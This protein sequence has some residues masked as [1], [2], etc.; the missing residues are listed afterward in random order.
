MKMSN[1]KAI[2]GVCF[3]ILSVIA[4]NSY[5]QTKYQWKQTTEGG[6]T[7]RYVTGD[8]MHAR[9][10]R[11]KNGLTV[12]LSVNKKEPR[13]Q[14]LIGVRAGSNNDPNDHTGLAHYLEHLLFKGT[15][16][17]GTSDWAKEK[18]YIDEI[19]KL[20]NT[21]NHTKDVA[22]RKAVYHQI[23]SVSGI[24]AHYAI[25]NEYDKLMAEMGAQATNAHT[26]VEETIYQED[27]PSSS[28]DKY[29]AVQAER[30]RY[31]V[32]RL[33]HTELEAVY[34]EKNR[35][36]DNDGQKVFQVMMNGIFPTHNYGQHTTIGTIEHLKN[37]SLTA[38]RNFYN[39]WYVPNNMAIVL[40]GDIDPATVIKKINADFAYMQPKPLHEYS[41]APEA[42]MKAPVI[43]EVLGPDAESV[44][45]AYRM[46]GALDSKAQVLLEVLSDMLSNGKAGLLDLNLN[47]Q[48]KVLS[49]GAFVQPFKDYSMLVISG[50]S[51]KGQS[52]DELKNL[53]QEQIEK[54]KKGDFDPSLVKAIINN[55]RLDQIRG[56]E[57]NT[58]RAN[59]LMDAFIKHKGNNW[60]DDVDFLD[61]MAKVTKA[62]LVNFANQYLGN[63][64]ALVY[65]RLGEDKSI[66]KVEKPAITPIFIDKTSKSPFLERIAAMPATTVNPLW[67]DYQKDIQ[68][69]MVG[70]APM[71]YVPNKD[72]ALFSLSYRFDMGSWNNKMLPYAADYL[73]Y[74]GTDKASAEQL[75]RA[76]YNIA[77]DYH[78]SV[79]GDV[80]TVNITGLQDNFNQAVTLF[81]KL[82]ANCEPNQNAFAALKEG[83]EKSRENNKLNKNAIA[84]GLIQYAMYGP[85]NPF[86]NQ[87]SNQELNAMTADTLVSLLHSLYANKHTVIYYGPLLKAQAQT[88][89][90]R[91]HK[92]PLNFIESDLAEKFEKASQNNNQVLFADYKQVQ[93]EVYWIRNTGV[94]QP[95][96]T[97]DI[98]VYNKYFGGG[99]GSVVFQTIRESKALAYSTFAQYASPDKKEERYS[100]IGYVG[101]QADKM[102]EA[103]NGMNDLYNDMPENE[104][105]LQNAKQ[106][107]KQD[108]AT[109]RITNEDIIKNYLAAQR[110]GLNDDYRK[111]VYQTIDHITFEDI[112]KIHNENLKNKT[113]TYC[114]LGSKDKIPTDVLKKYG[115]VKRL[116]LEEI[117][118]Y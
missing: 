85:K 118:G 6:Y 39:K 50:K 60:L 52:L 34:E 28:L 106:S 55:E 43:R 5:S 42:P 114:I 25:A 92:L 110:L 88:A 16:K 63:N 66:V 80:T 115:E 1:N 61:Q 75:T 83:I 56:L 101:T 59:E 95:G 4:I 90:T 21:Y 86:N 32:F 113:F 9:F 11:L 82:I 54:I 87:L 91:L 38:I 74:L 57:N 111:E 105:L 24:A 93:A 27:I 109:E 46:P 23:D 15:D 14:T 19:E 98:N 51:K 40:S 97:T 73:H 94:Y 79:T 36:L 84:R 70:L 44:N 108:I 29:L 62:Q 7:Y 104:Q 100:E 96:N 99:M 26:F 30:F 103:I 112:Q 67:L 81:E 68:K 89:L 45:I 8:P 31:P 17:Y 20:Y 47:Q 58:N 41:P 2:K 102:Q 13:I 64:Y 65:K 3:L 107:L 22:A 53:L 78:I 10:Y 33:F 37:P 72:N 76:F 117:F 77:C 69:G 49:S 48:Q 35:G 116:S 12:I 18:P 71:L